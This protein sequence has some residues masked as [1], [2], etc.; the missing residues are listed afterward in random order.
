V[1]RVTCEGRAI[2]K[3]SVVPPEKPGLQKL[4]ALLMEK[5]YRDNN[6]TTFVPSVVFTG[7]K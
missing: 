1:I 3:Q 7:H 2:E 4:R 6:G 5:P